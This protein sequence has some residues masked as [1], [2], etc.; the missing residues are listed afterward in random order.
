MVTPYGWATWGAPTVPIAQPGAN[1]MAAPVVNLE[2][3]SPSP[4][5]ATNATG[6]NVAGATNATIGNVPPVVNATEMRPQWAVPYP[7]V[8]GAGSEYQTSALPASTLSP[9]TPSTSFNF[10]AAQFDSLYSPVPQPQV[11]LG[12]VAREWR[13]KEQTANARTYTNEDINRIQAQSGGISG[14][15]LNAGTAAVPG[16]TPAGTAPVGG[17]AAAP[18]AQPSNPLPNMMAQNSVPQSP[19]TSEGQNATQASPGEPQGGTRAT[20]PR[21]ASPLP[22]LLLLGLLAITAGLVTSRLQRLRN[23][24]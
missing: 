19:A 4:V 24:R 2:P 21:A 10:G 1:Y 13:Q 18:S 6:N 16:N 12:E 11:S 3:V 5:G 17:N 15:A 8:V 14:T 7:T 23:R 9:A 20:L 22:T